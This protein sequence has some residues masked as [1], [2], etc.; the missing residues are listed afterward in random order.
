MESYER[1]RMANVEVKTELKLAY[2]EIRGVP[3]YE[4]WK[5]IIQNV[6]Y[7]AW[8]RAFSAL[9]AAI[10]VI[11]HCRQIRKEANEKADERFN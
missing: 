7:K 1:R 3:F 2:E 9:G 8:E 10:M 4:F 6:E 5:D 11:P